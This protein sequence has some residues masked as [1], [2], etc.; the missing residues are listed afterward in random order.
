MIRTNLSPAA[1]V[2]RH[3]GLIYRFLEVTGQYIADQLYSLPSSADGVI[4][5]VIFG[6]Q[7]LARE[8]LLGQIEEGDFDGC[9]CDS[10][11]TC[12]VDREFWEGSEK[13][14]VKMTCGIRYS[15]VNC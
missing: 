13:R 4:F 7:G 2:R 12:A 10:E 14:W 5:G 3:S 11:Y 9:S 8:R 1:V 15:T 6:D